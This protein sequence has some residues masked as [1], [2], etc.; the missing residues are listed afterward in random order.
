MID[1]FFVFRFFYRKIFSPVSGFRF[2]L[3]LFPN[4]DPVPIFFGVSV[5]SDVSS[6]DRSVNRICPAPRGAF[7]IGRNSILFPSAI[8]G[9]ENPFVAD[10]LGYVTLVL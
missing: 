1:L 8:G 2:Q 6:K 7:E 9:D 10:I 5:R 4:S 3:D